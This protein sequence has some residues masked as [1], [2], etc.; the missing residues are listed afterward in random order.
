MSLESVRAWLYEHAPDLPI[1]ET[2]QSTYPDAE[3]LSDDVLE[4]LQHARQQEWITAVE[5]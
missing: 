1:I 3:G 5:E 4:F 2:L